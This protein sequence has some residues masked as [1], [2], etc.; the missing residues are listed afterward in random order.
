MRQTIQQQS[1]SGPSSTLTSVQQNSTVCQRC[2]Y[3]SPSSSPGI[4]R[5]RSSI[6]AS[7]SS[8]SHVVP[9]TPQNRGGVAN[10][11]NN[12]VTAQVENS[13]DE[14]AEVGGAGSSH[15]HQTSA[16]LPSLHRTSSSIRSPTRI[17]WN[18]AGEDGNEEI[19]SPLVIQPTATLPIHVRRSMSASF[20]DSVDRQGQLSLDIVSNEG[21]SNS[22]PKRLILV[23]RKDDNGQKQ[24]GG[25]SPH[26][27]NTATGSTK[28]RL[29]ECG[30]SKSWDSC[31]ISWWKSGGIAQQGSSNA[32]SS[33]STPC[34]NCN[35]PS[36]SKKLLPQQASSS[37]GSNSCTTSFA[38]LPKNSRAAP[39]PTPAKSSFNKNL[40][41]SLCSTSSSIASN[42]SSSSIANGGKSSSPLLGSSRRM[43]PP[44]PGGRFAQRSRSQS[45]HSPRSSEDGIEPVPPSSPL[46]SPTPTPTTHRRS[47]SLLTPLLRRRDLNSRLNHQSQQSDSNKRLVPPTTT[48]STSG[49]GGGGNPASSSF[50]PPGSP[51]HQPRNSAPSTPREQRKAKSRPSYLS[52]ASSPFRQLF[53]NSPLLSRR[54]NKNRNNDRSNS[55]S[56]NSGGRTI[57]DSSDE[58]GAGGSSGSLLL[59]EGHHIRNLSGNR[60]S[61]DS[62]TRSPTPSSRRTSVTSINAPFRDLETFQKQQL[63]QKVRI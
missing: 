49:S 28:M 58:E 6:D 48:S 63:R 44:T 13:I 19:S 21:V 61:V 45:Q 9:A 52:S 15:Q 24:S 11:S 16:P 59:D 54:R 62:P 42:S 5:R 55:S 14:N 46:S 17:C 31:D 57:I 41:A 50:I 22:P 53:A 8:S 38:T 47:L 34:P 36:T 60:S 35:F 10:K 29:R 43:T 33:S 1:G 51:Q 18:A 23:K 32:A 3:A 37:S 12:L 30:K 4:I 25:P 56:N 26:T 7:S 2:D 20:L 27:E 40:T 39:P